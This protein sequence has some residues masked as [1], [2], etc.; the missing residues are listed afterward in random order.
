MFKQIAKVKLFMKKPFLIFL[1]A[2]FILEF[3]VAFLGPLKVLAQDNSAKKLN[4]QGLERELKTFQG[5]L[6]GHDKQA[7]SLQYQNIQTSY[8]KV[9][10]DLDA[11]KSFLEQTNASPEIIQRLEKF[12]A[13][14]QVKIGKALTS[15]SDY[16]KLSKTVDGLLP[17]EQLT[18]TPENPRPFQSTVDGQVIRK[19]ESSLKPSFL[20]SVI[21]SISKTI[22]GKSAG[23]VSG[24]LSK[25]N[26]QP[27]QLGLLQTASISP[28]YLA[29]GGEIKFSQSIKDLADS[30][31]KDP[32]NILNFVKNN[33]DYV[34]YYGVKKGTDA[35]LIER[36]G[37]DFDQ[38]AL[39]IA[40]LRYAGYPAKYQ[41][42]QI[43]LSLSQAMNL[44]GVDDPIVVAKMFSKTHIPYILYTDANDAPL[45][46]VI[47]HTWVTSYITYDYTQGIVQNANEA[48]KMWV[49][50]EPSLK[51]IYSSQVEDVVD[52]MGFNAASF[53]EAYLQGA[54]GS[55]KPMQAF[56]AQIESY[57]TA[58]HPDL[59][60]DD[61]LTKR[62][63][64]SEKLEFIPNTLPYEIIE[65]IAEYAQAPESLKHKINFRLTDQAQGTELLN[66]TTTLADLADKQL[67]ITYTA[68]SAADQQ[69]IDSFGDIYNVVPLSL[70][71]IKPVVKAQGVIKCGG[72][73][74]AP[75]IALGKKQNLTMTFLTPG[76]TN[77]QLTTLTEDII[78]KEV[79]AG[80][81]E[82][83][84]INTDRIVL[85]ETRP[86]QDTQTAEFASSQKLYRTALNYLGRLQESHN[87]L[88]QV[89][90]G[91]FTNEATRAIVFNGIDISYQAGQPY[92][93]T[94]KGL[95]IDSSSKVN[96]FSHFGSDIK[97]NQTRFMHLFGL[98][99]S[100][101]E[102]SIFE[103][104]Y[105]IE[106]MSTVKGL[107]MINQGQIPN[108]S[109]IK[110]TSANR[111]AINA[112][113][114]SEAL[115]TKFRASVDNGNTIYTP[116]QQFTYQNWTGLVYIDLN[117]NNGDAGYIIGEGL[118]GG[119]TVEQWPSGWGHLWRTHLTPNLTAQIISP[120]PNQIFTQ[121]SKIPW[122]AHYESVV[123]GQLLYGWNESFPLNAATTTGIQTLRSGYGTN[124]SVSVVIKGPQNP[125]QIVCYSELESRTLP[126]ASGLIAEEMHLP[127]WIDKSSGVYKQRLNDQ[128]Q[129]NKQDDIYTHPTSFPDFFDNLTGAA[130]TTNNINNPWIDPKTD[131][132]WTMSITYAAFNKPAK[133]NDHEKYYMN[134]R[135]V[136][137]S[138]KTW[139]FGKKIWIKNPITRKAIVAGILDY[140]PAE[141]TGRV[142]GASPEVFKAIGVNND[143]VVEFCW[144][145][146]EAA[147][148]SVIS[149]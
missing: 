67:A 15:S 143:S 1:M 51:A 77:G 142:A 36:A 82:G 64:Q 85:P 56:R 112:L 79:I 19:K 49:P 72:L 60:Y 54:Y 24:V 115:K 59:V 120:T 73:A 110:I 23:Q 68:A 119:Y 137:G 84:A 81:D 113:I 66:C 104:D 122:F 39:L 8:Q 131:K 21:S 95:R 123:A 6:A 38:S 144:A 61:I 134:M 138:S 7:L 35:T 31:G 63:R 78:Q 3:A 58:N 124:K 53:Y 100:L 75:E 65:N 57:L 22:L 20:S 45:F 47:E 76:Q 4:A 80:N 90:G 32:L 44:L 106:A 69:V 2:V 93:F 74:G 42:G 97:K 116:N 102:S 34:P 140:G 16:S 105:N 33:I 99:G 10:V 117:P 86:Q 96:Y 98:E 41:R 135:W 48:D 103:E 28:E 125:M 87:E 92:S 30:L 26:S 149:Y 108:R 129:F 147:Y 121:G 27:L 132:Y 43:K 146:Q 37:N 139:W 46:F 50:L 62:Y 141:N 70:V 114:I 136:Y 52:E 55:Q 91:E 88:A 127:L 17:K 128:E 101:N 107:K 71:H 94:W 130:Q 9:L 133:E 111:N 11:T 118:N 126:A 148:G 109:V 18:T 13:D 5:L 25:I 14:Y 40:L 89:L 83:V 12:K 145:D 29:E